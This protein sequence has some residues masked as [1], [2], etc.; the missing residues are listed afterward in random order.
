MLTSVSCRNFRC[1][2]GADV[3]LE[4]LTALVGPNGSGKSALLRAID[5]AAGPTWPSLQRL[6]FP[7]DFTGY[8]D[9]LELIVQV[10]FDPPTV[11]ERDRIGSQHSIAA[12]RLR[13]R[14]YKRRSG[15]AV[16][17]DPNFDYDPLDALGEVPLECVAAS[18][19]R[20]V[21]QRPHR[22]TSL[23]RERAGCVLID[24][25]RAVTQ[26]LPGARGSVLS[27][28]LAPALRDLD[29]PMD[30]ATGKKTRR[31][32]FQERYEHATEVLRSSYVREVE[33]TIDETAR[34]TLGFAGAA[35]S[36]RGAH[37]SFQI[38][39]PVNPYASLRLVYSEEGLDF[40]AED[41]GLGIQSAIVVGI[42][43]AL[44]AHGASAG[45]VL[46]D[47]PE[48]YLH[49]QAQ[50]HF[51][52][53]LVDL[54]ERGGTQVIY[55]THSPVFADAT[56]FESLRLLRRP[57]G[58][59]TSIAAVADDDRSALTTAKA[60]TKL[61]TEYDATRSEALF[62]SAVL[63]VEGKADLVAARTVAG[64]L[65]FDLDARNLS[66]LECGGKTSIQFHARLCRS[67]GIP[68]CAL[69]DD[70]LWPTP[71]DTDEKAQA[72]FEKDR[73][74]AVRDNADIDGAA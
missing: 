61:L 49:P 18:G 62:A 5:L 63:L 53:V 57:P 13:C 6:R 3:T 38:A 8:D 45:T 21:Q 36:G 70:D 4:S 29:K 74:R 17:G 60:A 72:Q 52:Q 59:T 9:S 71:A 40:P 24:H 65:E 33:K 43:E 26:H 41:V 25:R 7:Y 14:P 47:E 11:T 46:I 56:R 1:I 2:A 34:R 37:V 44:R 66:I 27:R 35:A 50:R 23:M 19:G 31:Q 28:I 39:D 10:G 68:V 64:K 69:Y 55:S 54:V 12:L 42:F 58:Q 20:P 15:S 32:A 48:M 16:A 73:Q 30:A 22:V 67:L 51:H